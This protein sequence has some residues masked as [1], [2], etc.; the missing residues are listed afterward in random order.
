MKTVRINK[1]CLTKG[2]V[3]DWF[4]GPVPWVCARPGC[5]VRAIHYADFVEDVMDGFVPI[6]AKE[7][8]A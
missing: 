1:T 4:G 6:T 2:H 3:W 5:R 7:A 8:T